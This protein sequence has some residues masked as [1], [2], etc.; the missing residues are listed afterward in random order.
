MQ[1][2]KFKLQNSLNHE[3]D[4]TNRNF[5]VFANQPQGL[6]FSKTLSV[7]RLGDENFIPYS[8]INLDAIN[9]ELL[10]YDDKLSDKYQKYVEFIDF[11]S[12]KPI[13]LLYQRPNSFTWYRRGV[14]IVSLTKTEVSYQDNM[15]HCPFVMQTLTF[16]EDNEANVIETELTFE[17]EGGK[18]Y[19]ITYPINYGYDT[20]S[21]LGL[22]SVGLLDTPIE[23]TITGLTQNPQY[24]LYDNNNNVYGRGKFNGTFDKIYVNSKESEE[25]IK[26]YYNNLM[27]NNPFSY[28]DLT[29]GSPNE[30]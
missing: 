23:F 18:I 20:I 25:Q 2:R 19:P 17:E 13:Q 29:V 27:L 4:L 15:L 12:H 8:M 7:L 6:G 16:W 24:I 1:Y 11:I 9:F 28:Q 22:T 10:F 5:K 3:Y 14:E 21:N 26:L 30:V